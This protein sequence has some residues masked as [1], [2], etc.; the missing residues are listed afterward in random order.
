MQI[1]LYYNNHKILL[2]VGK[3]AREIPSDWQWDKS[4]VDYKSLKENI[5]KFKE[6]YPEAITPIWTVMGEIEDCRKEA[7]LDF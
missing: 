3:M 7:S 6:K 1:L 2:G 5:R 4:I